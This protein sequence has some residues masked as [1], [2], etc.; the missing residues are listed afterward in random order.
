MIPNLKKVL[1]KK[2]DWQILKVKYPN[3]FVVLSKEIT[4]NGKI[5]K[6]TVKVKA[7]NLDKYIP[8]GWKIEKV[9]SKDAK[10]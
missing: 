1:D 9:L 4:Y 3:M 7:K 2:E 5:Y 6:E 8:L 10:N